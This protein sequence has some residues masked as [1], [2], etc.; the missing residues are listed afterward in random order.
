MNLRKSKVLSDSIIYM[1]GELVARIIPFLMLPYFSRVL[2]VK[3]FGALSLFQ[4]YLALFVIL[5]GM[6]FDGAISRY[7]YYYGDRGI[8]SLVIISYI[9]SCGLAGGGIIIGFLTNEFVIYAVIVSLFMSMYNTQLTLRQCYKKPLPYIFYS[10]AFSFINV[11]LTFL[12]YYFYIPDVAHRVY[13]L[14][15]S[16]VFVVAISSLM[17][18]IK[19]KIYKFTYL[20]IKYLFLYSSPILLHSLSFYGKGQFDR[21]IIANNYSLSSLGIYSAG[22]QIASILIILLMAINRAVQPYLFEALKV[23]TVTGRDIKKLFL[24]STS[25]VFIPYVFCSLLPRGLYVYFLGT[26]FDGVKQYVDS[27]VLGMSIQI[28]YFVISNYLFYHG[29][30]KIIALSTFIS[31]VF[32]IVILCAMLGQSLNYIPYILFFSNLLSILLMYYFCISRKLF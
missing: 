17:F 6:S 28:P 5:I 20:H 4:S 7:K 30:T 11:S 22:F 27:F 14:V 19:N 1:V 18:F 10:F 23:K 21:V 25:T 3:E 12:F 24:V 16:L 31:T 32:H 2:G 9:I 26:G 13:A 8:T 15:I 29:Q